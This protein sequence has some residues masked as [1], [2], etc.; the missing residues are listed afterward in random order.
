M[1]QLTRQ[2]ACLSACQSVCQPAWTWHAWLTRYTL[3]LSSF[4]LFAISIIIAH[5]QNARQ[6]CLLAKQRDVSTLCIIS[7][8]TPTS[9]IR[10]HSIFSN[11]RCRAYDNTEK[12]QS[13]K[14]NGAETNFRLYTGWCVST[15]KLEEK[16][17]HLR[18][19]AG[20][21]FGTRLQ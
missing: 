20:R 18:T 9:R 14:N 12:P 6:T 19:V 17:C 1:S 5:T 15:T 10:W 21:D 13:K 3:L 4:Q 2:S 8:P 7:C 16:Q 11:S